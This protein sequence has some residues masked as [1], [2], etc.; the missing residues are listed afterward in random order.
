MPQP[1]Q[2][3]ESHEVSLTINGIMRILVQVI[4]IALILIGCY[5]AISVCQTVL[6]IAFDPAAIEPAVTAMAKTLG[7][8]N[9]QIKIDQETI[10]LGGLLG[11]TALF[12][13]YFLGALLTITL[14][15]AGARLVYGAHSERREMLAAMQEFLATVRQEGERRR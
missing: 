7:V 1:T 3:N 15:N 6:Q 13:W 10:R 14:V 5:L 8:D 2:F 11:G 9:A 12:G 4:G